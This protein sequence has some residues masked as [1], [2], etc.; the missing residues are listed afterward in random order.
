MLL[1]SVKWRYSILN[2]GLLNRNVM[3]LRL[4]PNIGNLDMFGQCIWIV[5][6]VKQN[7]SFVAAIVHFVDVDV[8]FIF[9]SFLLFLLWYTVTASGFQPASIVRPLDTKGTLLWI[10]SFT[11][12]M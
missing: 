4:S 3:I 12:Q 5:P 7:E 1:I 10:Y 11:Q 9:L 2:G 6:S 8:T